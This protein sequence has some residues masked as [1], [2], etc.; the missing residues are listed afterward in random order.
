MR[1]NKAKK[2][3]SLY[4]APDGPWLSP[5]DHQALEVHMEVC[6]SCRE[7]CRE[8]RE[9]IGILQNCWTESNSADALASAGKSGSEKAAALPNQC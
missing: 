1:C 3:I 2:L 8:S 7:D 9:V 5:K 4:V 6:E